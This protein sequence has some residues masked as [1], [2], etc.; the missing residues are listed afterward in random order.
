[1]YL[2]C[3]GALVRCDLWNPEKVR[4]RSTVPTAGAILAGITDQF[5]V[6]EYHTAYPERLLTTLY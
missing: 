3:P 2:Q 6:T 4:D 1:V 5:G